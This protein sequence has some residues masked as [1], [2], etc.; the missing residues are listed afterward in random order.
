M[1]DT[2]QTI[3]AQTIGAGIV[4]IG[5][6]DK[7]HVAISALPENI[8]M[9]TKSRIIMPSIYKIHNIFL[10]SKQSYKYHFMSQQSM[11]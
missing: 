2:A 5:Q 3:G 4:K 9:L 1:R 6:I 10:K 11:I 7:N 8:F